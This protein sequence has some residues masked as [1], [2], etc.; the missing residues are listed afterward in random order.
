MSEN[1]GGAPGGWVKLY[2]VV[3]EKGWLTNHK[4][5]TF[6]SWCLLKASHRVYTQMVGYQKVTL[7]PGQFIFGRKSAAEEL[8]MSERNIRTCLD[9]LIRME[10]MTIKTTN[11]FSLVT[12]VNWRIYQ[13]EGDKTDQQSDQQT[14]SQ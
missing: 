3:L 10:N 14:T 5:W 8:N 6:W 11:K 2:R 9:S 13:G 4:L 1:N 12:V 7:Q